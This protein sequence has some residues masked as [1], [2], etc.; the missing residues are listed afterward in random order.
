MDRPR[1]FVPAHIAVRF[2]KDAP[3]FL[4][5]RDEVGHEL[6]RDD[7]LGAYWSSHQMLVLGLLDLL[8]RQRHHLAEGEREVE[9]RVSNRA[10]VRI[11]TWRG[12]LVVARYNREVDLLGLVRHPASLQDASQKQVQMFKVQGSGFKDST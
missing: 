3:V 5:S 10:D 1:S 9:W 2:R 12:R 7:D 4:K 8:V 6:H 11:S